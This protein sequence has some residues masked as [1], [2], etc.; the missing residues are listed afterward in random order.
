[1]EPVIWRSWISL[2]AYIPALAKAVAHFLLLSQLR[3][4]FEDIVI[5]RR[6][7]L[8]AWLS[9]TNFLVKSDLVP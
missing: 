3:D 9:E 8:S 2:C 7:F 4:A 6:R 1:M 5:G